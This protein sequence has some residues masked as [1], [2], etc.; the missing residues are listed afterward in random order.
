MAAPQTYANHARY[1]FLYHA[2]AFPIFV[3]NLGWAIREAV[4]TPSFDEILDV[5]V[6]VALVLLFFYARLF[7]LT[8]Q[9]RVI[10]LEERARLARLLPPDLHPRIEEFTRGQLVA[11][12]FASDAELPD[13][14]RRVLTEG[15]RDQKAIKQAIRDWRP[16]HLRV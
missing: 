8:A 13:L 6:A 14:A 3:L 2:I 12:R 4:R 16:D 7:A 5:L 1:V 15:I 11:L 9:D 10:R